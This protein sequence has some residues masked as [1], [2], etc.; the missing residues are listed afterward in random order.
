MADENDKARQE[1][2]I[3]IACSMDRVESTVKI[4]FSVDTD[5]QSYTASDWETFDEQ[6]RQELER[7]KNAIFF[8]SQIRG[9]ISNGNSDAVDGSESAPNGVDSTCRHD[10]GPRVTS[11]CSDFSFSDFPIEF[12]RFLIDRLIGEGGFARVFLARDP[13]LQRAVALKLL[14]P[15]VL[16]SDEARDRFEREARAAARL[17]HPN[18]VPV[19][20]SGSF[21]RISF[22]ASEYCAGPTLDAWQQNRH[23]SWTDAAHLVATLAEAVHHAHQRGVLHRDLKPGNV[24]FDSHHDENTPASVL[25]KSLR[26]T[27]FGLAKFRDAEDSI[28]TIEGAIVGTPAYMSPEQA[29][30]SIEIGPAADIYSLGVILFQLVSGKL[31]YLGENHLATLRFV[32]EAVPVKLTSRIPG[33]TIPGDLNAICQKAMAADESERYQNS[34]ALAEDLNRCIEGLPVLA[35]KIGMVRRLVRWTRRKPVLSVA[36]I[37]AFMSLTVGLGISYWQWHRSNRNFQESV[38]QANRAKAHLERINTFVDGFLTNLQLRNEP[39]LITVDERQHLEEILE[40]QRELVHEETANQAVR[41]NHLRAYHRMIVIH[42]AL[43]EYHLVPAIAEETQRWLGHPESWTTEFEV[44]DEVI[45]LVVELSLGQ[46]ESLNRLG[47][48]SRSLRSVDWLKK[49]LVEHHSL[50]NETDRLYYRMLVCMYDG[51]T[52]RE[53]NR[54]AKSVV[55]LEEAER[56]ALQLLA[57]MEVDSPTLD[58]KMVVG[59]C[60]CLLNQAG[61]YQRT[62]RNDAACNTIEQ[63]FSLLQG[64]LEQEPRNLRLRHS[65]AIAHNNFANNL[66][67]LR[68]AERK[69]QARLTAIKFFEA[70]TIEVPDNPVYTDSLIVALVRQASFLTETNK[71]D[72]AL[73][74][75]RRAEELAKSK[76]SSSLQAKIQ[77]VN[78]YSQRSNLLSK[79]NLTEEARQNA[80]KAFELAK[81]YFAESPGYWLGQ[82]SLLEAHAAWLKVLIQEEQSLEIV[83]SVSAFK[84]TCKNI[85]RLRPG[86]KF[87]KNV[88]AHLVWAIRLQSEQLVDMKRYSEITTVLG[89]VLAVELSEGERPSRR[90]IQAAQ[91][92]AKILNQW[93]KQVES[94]GADWESVRTSG[95]DW[96]E[97]AIVEKGYKKARYLSNNP[98]WESLRG[99]PR[100]IQLINRI[101][102]NK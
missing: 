2:M 23:V 48:T 28:I 34:F 37:F 71:L 82:K 84:S 35:R 79:M 75:S 72:I 86:E 25:A 76:L 67:I 19:F 13:D 101:K 78:L 21:G 46:I 70:L 26:I 49:V 12:G 65:L 62:D 20:E 54:L 36:L 91:S 102:E 41:K 98:L 60:N 22:I 18:I 5:L 56:F 1:R 42:T 9:N 3:E 58:L 93:S 66:S 83:S 33:Q 96:L 61:N 59:I 100:M 32:E 92:V 29:R 81:S 77:L 89:E 24:L 88:R 90:H 94:L 53:N 45:I 64:A 47:N 31:P 52:C 55:A 15:Q 87:E 74:F 4:N 7:I 17:S 97:T 6:E 10:N 69:S 44:D 30:A 43:G 11:A 99:D 57:R 14:K 73:Q 50:L 63:V 40:V 27:D 85:L 68:D 8:L 80:R 39:T 95:V 16:A 38:V 51:V